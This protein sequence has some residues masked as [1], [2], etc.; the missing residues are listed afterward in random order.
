MPKSRKDFH[1]P[2]ES[3]NVVGM[4]GRAIVHDFNGYPRTGFALG[5]F[6]DRTLAPP[7]DD[8]MQDVP[9]DRN[10]DMIRL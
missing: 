8:L 10:A 5:C 2:L 7:V 6:V 3:K 1:F 4:S 9:R